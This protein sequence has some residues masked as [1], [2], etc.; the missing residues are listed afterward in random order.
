[1]DIQNNNVTIQINAK[2]LSGRKL[3]VADCDIFIVHVFT[4][5]PSF[6]L[7]YSGRDMLMTEMVDE[8][9][10]PAN[11]MCHLESG[12]VQYT[13]HYLPK[14]H[15]EQI[16]DNI[17]DTPDP[18]NCPHFH[19]PGFI[20]PRKPGDFI[21]DKFINSRPVVT[22]IYW[23]NILPG[24]HHHGP[25]HPGHP[26]D[27]LNEIGHIHHMLDVEIANRIKDVNTLNDKINNEI[28]R[29]TSEEEKL[30]SVID[31][32]LEE[33]REKLKEDY[34]ETTDVVDNKIADINKIVDAETA[35][36]TKAESDLDIKISQEAA[37]R[38]NGDDI[39]DNKIVMEKE[40]AQANETN[41]TDRISSVSEKFESFKTI[42][43]DALSSEITRAKA[44]ES[45]LN[46]KIQGV[47]SDLQAEVSRSAQNDINH[48][49]LVDTE[50]NRAKAVENKI[51]TD[52]ETEIGRAKD[53]EKHILDE[54]HTLQSDVINLATANDVYT[55][56]EVDTK[57]SN[58][59]DELATVNN[60]INNHI[61]DVSALQTKVNGIVADVDKAKADI[62]TEVAKC[63]AQNNKIAS[64]ITTEVN[65]RMNAD[66]AINQKV[67][68]L[69]GKVD[70]EIERAKA[71][72]K[73]NADAIAELAQKVTDNNTGYASEIADVNSALTL[74]IAR[75]K[76]AEKLV[77]DKID[78]INGDTSVVG[79][80]AHAV[81]DANHYT[82]D[83]I[84]KINSSL[85]I[86]LSEAD[87]KYQPKGEYVTV[88]AL[89]T[90]VNNAVA[91]SPQ[92]VALDSQI[93]AEVTRAKAAEQDIYDSINNVSDTL[94]A[95]I[96]D[97]NDMF[98]SSTGSGEGGDAFVTVNYLT[99][100]LADYY[101]KSE[102]DD[103]VVSTVSSGLA[104]YYMKSEVDAK[105]A[106]KADRSV[107]YT[108]TESDA[109]YLRSQTMTEA[110]Y[111][112]LATKDEN[113]L[114]IIL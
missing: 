50:S 81:K 90:A 60:W 66:V 89:G 67:D 104:D 17:G 23:R 99:D 32:K 82:D 21:D 49:N 22:E 14:N 47:V 52:L 53:A 80:I 70:A 92:F 83:E 10:I 58:V 109:R 37:A 4:Q 71:A 101:T 114:Y 85:S 69:E 11:V 54:V 8:L 18:M 113:V 33:A 31:E 56:A 57:I 30:V 105:V 51:A 61:V 59:N 108:K 94:E 38:Q 86:H 6:Y 98:D 87:A 34:K 46:D 12:V 96:K 9:T 77:S 19:H 64:D 28:E 55:K 16:P 97:L 5:D 36:A 35:R 102:I 75:A 13:Y 41:L 93:A 44:A 40:R 78:I 27:P 15:N 25:G 111:E 48:T 73:V 88:A 112:A 45:V 74:E 29:A 68:A 107:V 63:D 42:Q 76:A 84:A 79:S 103:V 110:E 91:N 26:G 2:D 7:S 24:H 43:T 100:S 62:L 39:L 1:M 65:D 20:P 72:E 3:R 106:N 95:A